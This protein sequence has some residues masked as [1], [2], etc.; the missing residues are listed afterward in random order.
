[1]A[2]LRLWDRGTERRL[3]AVEAFPFPS[4]ARQRFGFVHQ[5]LSSDGIRLVEDATRQWFRL[6]ARHPRAKIAMPSV[7][8]DA[9]W[10]EVT[11]HTREYDAFCADAFGRP[12]HHIPA[13]AVQ[14]ESVGA[15]LHAAYRLACADERSDERQ[16]PLLFRVDR[17][18]AITDG[19]HY[20][21]DCGGRAECYE[22]PGARCLRHI[23]GP[24]RS[25]G[26][27]WWTRREP[28][29]TGGCGGGTPG[30]GTSCGGG[31]GGGT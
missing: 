6:A 10:H 19:H 29:S 24:A 11:L 16:L 1:M 27:R 4:G 13:S 28:G 5:S 12:F 21:A 8:A 9:M 23:G 17:E 22:V 14:P 3:A 26:N 15:G 2:T 31:C 7:A 20:L 30:C 18:L 25:G